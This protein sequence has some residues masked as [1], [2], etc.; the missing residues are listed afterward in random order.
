MQV[1]KSLHKP[2]PSPPEAILNTIRSGY[3]RIRINESK[4]RKTII[5]NKNIFLLF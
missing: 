3:A 4:M 2:K 1:T 5:R